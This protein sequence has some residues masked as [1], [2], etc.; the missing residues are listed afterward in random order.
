M[1]VEYDLSKGVK[2]RPG[3]TFGNRGSLNF[4]DKMPENRTPMGSPSIP[5][6]T[7]AAPKLP[8]MPFDFKMS[9]AASGAGGGGGTAGGAGNSPLSTA[10]AGPTGS[11]S[12]FRGDKSTELSDSYRR[13]NELYD[14]APDMLER[15]LMQAR[16]A[17]TLAGRELRDMGTLA[18]GRTSPGATRR[19][20]DAT[21]RAFAGAAVDSAVQRHAMQQGALDRAIG[22]GSGIA[23]DL[24]AQEGLGIDAYRATTDSWKAAND[25][26]LARERMSLDAQLAAMN[27]Q[28]GMYNNM[29]SML[30]PMIGGAYSAV[31]RYF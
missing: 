10:I 15:N 21:N 28:M 18:G 5:P 12:E 29:F 2:A 19:L 24:R 8:P 30:G 14:T 20:A 17:S 16:D 31:G 23:G 13:A 7:P 1:A 22:A 9:G 4:T 26:A 6:A 27:M 25:A 3:G 11:L